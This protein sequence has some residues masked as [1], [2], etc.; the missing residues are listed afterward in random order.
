MALF[1]SMD[2][3]ISVRN[4]RK[5][6]GDFVAVAD[7]SFDVGDGEIVGI[8]GPNGAGKTTT[9]EILQGLRSSSGGE[10]SVLGMDPGREAA[11]IRKLIGSQLQESALPDRIKVWEALDLFGSLSPEGPSADQLLVDW[12]LDEK[13]DARFGSL[14]GGQ[15]QRLFVALALVNDPQVVFLDEMTTGL[16]PSSRRV[17]WELIRRIREGGSTVVLVTHFMDEAEQLCDRLVVVDGGAVVAEGSPQELIERYSAGVRVLF[18]A[19]HEDLSWLGDVP[20]VTEVV[21]ERGRRDCL[22]RRHADL[23]RPGL[24]DAEARA[25]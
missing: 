16:D 4:L 7:V 9:V 1:E 8:L 24:V 17:A 14:S 21:S 13:R 12:G 5:S 11:E 22:D 23:W 3:V 20:H 25:R 18:S 15:Q 6:Y 10:V 2:N 19:P